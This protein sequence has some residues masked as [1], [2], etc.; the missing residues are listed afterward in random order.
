M[1]RFVVFIV[2]GIHEIFLALW[3]AVIA[4]AHH[5]I[6]VHFFLHDILRNIKSILAF[7]DVFD[8]RSLYTGFFLYFPRCSLLVL[9]TILNGSL[10][11]YPSFIL[12]PI[13]LV[14]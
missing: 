9:L 1:I 7:S 8:N 5:Q 4:V 10:R 12:I 11:Q 2:S 14:K 13:V 3:F 6:P